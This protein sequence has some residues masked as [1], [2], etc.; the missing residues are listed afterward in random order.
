MLFCL[1]MDTCQRAKIKQSKL[2]L[3]QYLGLCSAT[4]NR[5]P[6]EK[7]CAHKKDLVLCVC[8]TYPVVQRQAAQDWRWQPED[9]VQDSAFHSVILHMIY[10]APLA[11]LQCCTEFQAEEEKKKKKKGNGHMSAKS[12]SFNSNFLKAPFI[13]MCYQPMFS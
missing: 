7:S 9:F 13:D 4:R 5:K 1:N 10:L 6:N 11:C 8:S 3:L 2:F 12:S